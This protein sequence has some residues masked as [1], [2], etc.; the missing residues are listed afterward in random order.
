MQDANPLKDATEKS[1][2]YSSKSATV[3]ARWTRRPETWTSQHS[4]PTTLDSQQTDTSGTGQ[5]SS[6]LKLGK[7]NDRCYASWK[8]FLQGVEQKI[9]IKLP[10]SAFDE[11]LKGDLDIDGK[12]VERRLQV[13]HTLRCLLG[14]VIESAILRDRVRWIYE[15]LK[16]VEG[17]SQFSRVDLVNL[18]D[19][20]TGSGR[21]VAI[22][23]M[24]SLVTHK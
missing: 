6:L 12:D 19:Q 23:I 5:T 2:N 24:P 21:N 11:H 22:V 8:S 1:E 3:P 18:F 7:L 13:L 4:L 14:P 17:D 15:M 10:E 9:S 16:E 20:S